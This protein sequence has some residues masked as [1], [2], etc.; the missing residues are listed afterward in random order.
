MTAPRAVVRAILLTP[1]REV[2]LIKVT[3][4]STGWT[5]WITPGGGVEPGELPEDALQRELFEETGRRGFQIGPKTWTRDHSDTWE[6]V[7]FRQQESLYLVETP[8]FTPTNEFQCDSTETKAF[9][10][11]RWWPLKEI[12]ASKEIFVP[13]RMGVLLRELLE[14]GP[15]ATPIDAGI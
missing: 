14:Q 10:A 9:R 4:W 1:D 7:P 12:E 5:A 11:F 2:L 6:G 13:G 8:R 3:E 15:P